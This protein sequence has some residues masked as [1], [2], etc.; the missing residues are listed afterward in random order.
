[1]RTIIL[2]ST[3]LLAACSVNAEPATP[4]VAPD[5]TTLHGSAPAEAL[6][7]AVF[8]VADHLGHTRTAE[9][10]KGRPHVVW[11]YPMAGTPG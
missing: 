11:F 5:G 6:G 3:L 2:L 1:M 4:A 10:L 9:D 8:S 7:L